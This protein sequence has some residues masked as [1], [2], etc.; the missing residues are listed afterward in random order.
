MVANGIPIEIPLKDYIHDLD[1]MAM[2][3]GPKTKLIMICNP[4]NPTGTIVARKEL[5]KFFA[6]LPDNIIVVLDEVYSDFVESRDF[7]DGIELI[8]QGKNVI[9]VRSFSKIYGLAGI[10]IGYALG[11]QELIAALNG[12]REVFPVSRLAEAA[13]RAALDDV[14]FKDKVL[15]GTKRGRE[16]LAKAFQKMSLRCLPSHTNFVFVDLRMDAEKVCRLLLDKGIM[17]YPGNVW[18]TP[19]W[20]RITIG[21]SW[22]NEKVIN[23]LSEVLSSRNV[24]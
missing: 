3:I 1:K 20:A 9:S 21:T 16:K 14:A 8:R 12:V 5:E 15:K 6:G 18:G 24:V 17:I 7:L 19:T 22:E 23:A 10:R 4:N 11:R 2:A 13:A